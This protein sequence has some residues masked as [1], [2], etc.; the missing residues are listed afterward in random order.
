MKHKLKKSWD[1]LSK[2][3][4]Q[5]KKAGNQF[6]RLAEEYYGVEWHQLAQI[7]DNDPIIDTIDYGTDTLTFE[8]FDAIVRSALPGQNIGC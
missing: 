2:L 5:H 1:K 3:A 6:N 7:V 8:D 4:S